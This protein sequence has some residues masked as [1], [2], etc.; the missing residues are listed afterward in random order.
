[1]P[2][3]RPP[4]PISPRFWIKV[5]IKESNEC[6]PWKASLGFGGYGKFKVKGTYIVAHIIAFMLANN[7]TIEEGK[8]IMHTCDNKIC[9]NPFHL[10]LG[11]VSDNNADKV[12]KG[13]HKFISPW[14]RPGF[15][16]DHRW[17]EKLL[18]KEE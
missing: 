11:T 3:I 14:S 6:W 1:M 10:K 17:K 5:E 7:T 8:I 9:C 13:R 18:C 15:H 2:G 12:S 16:K 4:G